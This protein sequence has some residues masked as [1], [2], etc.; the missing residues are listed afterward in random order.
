[1]RIIQI[2]MLSAVLIGCSQAG[3]TALPTCGSLPQRPPIKLAE[4]HLKR[5]LSEFDGIPELET[6]VGPSSAYSQ[7]SQ[8]AREVIV[9]LQKDRVTQLHPVNSELLGD[10]CS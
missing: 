9:A 3:S 6:F 4:A 1:M 2:A 8:Q 7:S 5:C 10:I